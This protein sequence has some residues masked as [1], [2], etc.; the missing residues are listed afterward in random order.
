MLAQQHQ[1][2]YAA[3]YHPLGILCRPPPNIVIGQIDIVSPV[4]ADFGI[5]EQYAAVPYRIA[6][7]IDSEI[8]EFV[9]GL[10]ILFDTHRRLV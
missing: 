5:I 2:I 10:D 4:L 8:E 9:D 6:N 3:R 7:G 1:R